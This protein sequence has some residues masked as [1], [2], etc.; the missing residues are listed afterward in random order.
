MSSPL[1][2][3]IDRLSRLAILLLLV[4]SVLGAVLVLVKGRPAP[5][6]MAPSAL[7]AD[8][9]TF[10]AL[11]ETVMMS[12]SLAMTERPLFWEDRRPSQSATVLPV[13]APVSLDAGAMDQATLLGIFS[14]LGQSGVIIKV[15]DK[16]LR[17]L[18]N[19]Q[20]EDW[21]LISIDQN[22]AI[23]EGPGRNGA[24]REVELEL[25]QVP[26]RP[27]ASLGRPPVDG[28]TNDTT[29]MQEDSEQQPGQ[30]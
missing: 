26:V 25:Q 5:L 22:R 28:R 14:S 23:F 6:A 8:T 24:L 7:Q 18:L 21:T 1:S 27:T 10:Q 2:A 12:A 29:S 19:E 30:E 11:D 4:S 16:R 20:V 17:V 3:R 15:A 9:V 13:A